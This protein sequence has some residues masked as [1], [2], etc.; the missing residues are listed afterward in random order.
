M[1]DSGSKAGKKG[2]WVRQFPVGLQAIWGLDVGMDGRGWRGWRAWHGDWRR[3]REMEGIVRMEDKME[4]VEGIG[5]C[6][7]S[8]GIEQRLQYR[9]L[10]FLAAPASN[11]IPERQ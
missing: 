2:G 11:F 9:R 8:S 1:C 7:I 5:F 6:S 3:V 4:R 10:L